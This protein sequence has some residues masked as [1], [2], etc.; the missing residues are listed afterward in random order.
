MHIMNLLNSSLLI[1]KKNNMKVKF[2]K[3]IKILFTVIFVFQLSN[4][5]IGQTVIEMTHPS[6]AQ[7]VLLKVDNKKDADIIVYKTKSKKESRKWDCLWK[8]KNWGFANLSIFIM[9]NIA[10]TTLYKDDENGFVIDGKVYFTENA[11]ERGYNDPNFRLKGVFR[12]FRDAPSDNKVDSLKNV[13]PLSYF[14]NFNGNLNFSDTPISFPTGVRIAIVDSAM[15]NTFGEYKPT[16]SNFSFNEQLDKGTY[17]VLITSDNYRQY[18]ESFVVNGTDTALSKNLNITLLPNVIVNNTNKNSNNNEVLIINNLFFD[19][20]KYTLT[21]ASKSELDK[22]VKVMKLNSSI[23]LEL[24]GFTDSKGSVDYN[25]KLSKL[26][27]KASAN[28]LKNNG[29]EANRIIYKGMGEKMPIAINKFKGKD[30][31]QGRKYNRR[32]EIKIVS[33]EQTNIKIEAINVPED[34]IIKDNRKK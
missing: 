12:K 7:I 17:N 34:L 18:V 16:S 11:S 9:N 2:I 32:V 15:V 26:R 22:I 13:T 33:N 29:I 3:I 5:T 21:D 19:F 1:L 28:Y 6:D 27:A 31:I 10:D 8:F 14:I 30:S 4:N 23:K 24:L 20:A 25:L